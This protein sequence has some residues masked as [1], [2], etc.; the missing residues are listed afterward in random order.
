MIHKAISIR[1]PWLWL[2]TRPDVFGDEARRALYRDNLIKDV[3]NR[4]REMGIASDVW[5]HASKTPAD[6][7]DTLRMEIQTKFGIRVPSFDELPSGGIVGR[8][9][10]EPPV[11]EHAS[12]WFTGPVAYPIF[13]AQPVE[14]IKCN[15]ALGF[16]SLPA[17]IKLPVL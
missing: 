14:F 9:M 4:V 2:I 6:K 11:Y 5:L 7:Y 17:A 16:F 13:S 12:R 3:E 1:Q 10:F 15:G 8:A